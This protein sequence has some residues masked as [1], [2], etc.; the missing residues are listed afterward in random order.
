MEIINKLRPIL[1]H[2]T[3]LQFK[4]RLD[5]IE[6][7]E[8]NKKIRIGVFGD[9]GVGETSLTIVDKIL[10]EE[11]LKPF[12]AIVLEDMYF[13]ITHGE[14]SAIL[15]DC[16][17]NITN[18]D[19]IK[20][21]LNNLHKYKVQVF[22]KS[23]LLANDDI[24]IV[25]LCPYEYEQRELVMFD[26]VIFCVSALNALS[27]DNLQI[28]EQLHSFGAKE[29]FICFSRIEQ[30]KQSEIERLFKYISSK[31]SSSLPGASYCFISSE[32]SYKPDELIEDRY[33]YDKISNWLNTIIEEGIRKEKREEIT[34]Y[35]AQDLIESAIQL[36]RQKL[37]PL[38][39]SRAQK[40]E[41][42]R[43]R[44]Q[45]V[46]FQQ[47]AWE[48]LRIEC[49]KRE[50]DC[51]KVINDELS[52]NSQKVYD[53]LH[54]ELISTQN[55]KEWW[56][57]NLPL[58]LKIEIDSIS[59]YIDNKLQI[60]LRND[61]TWLNKELLVKFKSGAVDSPDAS[62]DNPNVNVDIVPDADEMKDLR[63]YRY[64]S[65]AGASA[66][67]TAMY[68]IVGPVGAIVSAGCGILG[69]RML[70]KEIAKQK[71]SLETSLRT[72][73]DETFLKIKSLI[74]SKVHEVYESFIDALDIKED[75]WVKA[76]KIDSFTCTE[77][78]EISNLNIIIEQ[79]NN[80][81]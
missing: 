26:A 75:G 24:E 16:D 11:V 17:G 67:A 44:E 18:I 30:I 42:F 57:N 78:S 14:G 66:L 54:L 5:E 49:E 56:K 28:M 41:N 52:N 13:T 64:A 9:Y 15:M 38:E 33:G 32:E 34:N 36:M 48:D 21:D 29:V 73:V 50:N 65:M 2:E 23:H 35:L 53:K 62:L 68:F 7:F 4:P 40:Y 72:L 10:C 63:K 3:L 69:D 58:R 60:R 79:L 1:G 47:L 43:T 77:D 19:S 27:V 71:S 80:L 76:H 6:R 20:H 55:P 51:V 70:T 45:N 8:A 25:K 22:T 31:L 12:I 46:R 37:L 59:T 39:E 74:P 81:K 61:Q